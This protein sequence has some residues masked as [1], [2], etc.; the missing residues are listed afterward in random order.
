MLDIARNK[1]KELSEQQRDGLHFVQ[2]GI[3]DLRTVPDLVRM[4]DTCK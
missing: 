1:Q 4:E 3:Y 2:H